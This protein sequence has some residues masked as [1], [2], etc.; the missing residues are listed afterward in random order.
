MDAPRPPRRTH[1]GL[2]ALLET[3]RAPLLLSPVSDVLAGWAL[4]RAAGAPA[5]DR[6]APA[7]ACLMGVGLLGAGMAQN[8][9][10]DREDDRQ[11]KPE[12]PIPRGDVSVAT[13]ART[14]AG[15]SLLALGLGSLVTGA[16]PVV[17]AILVLTAAYH[18]P[19]KR[20]RLPACLTLGALRGLDMSLGVV[21]AG[22]SLWLTD[23]VAATDLTPALCCVAY[24]LYIAGAALHASTDDAPGGERWSR[25]GLSL[26]SLVLVGLALLAMPGAAVGT[27]DPGPIASPTLAWLA[28]AVLLLSLGRLAQAWRRLPPPPLTGVALSN[29]YLVGVGLCL[30]GGQPW[31]AALVVALFV[32]SKR[33][34]RVFPPS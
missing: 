14:W 24:A 8:A 16:L 33:L 18:Y 6:A 22:G 26:A 17:L 19:L 3:L 29:L 11:R 34:M 21:A 31:A 13:V 25:A 20:A 10:A 30:A 5:A 12:R 4:A 2:F 32:L 23:P 15:L 27:G 1:V 9:L 7:L 28:C